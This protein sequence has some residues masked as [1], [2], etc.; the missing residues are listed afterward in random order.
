MLERAKEE[1]TRQGVPFAPKIPVGIMVETPAAAMAADKLAPECD[2]F[3]IGTN[4]LIQYS[5]AI[6][7]QNREVAY[8]YRPL[9][10]SILRQIQ[11][12]VREAHKAGISVSMCG[13]MAGDPM[14]SLV[15]LGLGLDELSM[16]AS[17]IPLVK[18][19]IRN[20][21][22]EDGRRLFEQMSK[23]NTAE[24]IERFVQAEM[25][26]RFGDVLAAT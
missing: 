4:D 8:L 3:S 2:F 7:R 5:M 24:E 14:Y 20:S 15:L 11:F 17:Q 26:A 16:V 18:R 21:N 25:K 9:H 10:I 6:D 1:L 22:A 13:E 19:I 23:L 12:T